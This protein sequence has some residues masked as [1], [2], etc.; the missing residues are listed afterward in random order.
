MSTM[1]PKLDQLFPGRVQSG[2]VLAAFSSMGVGG[3]AEFFLEVRSGRELVDAYRAALEDKLRITV[4]GLGSNMICADAGISGLVIRNASGE[5]EWHEHGCIVDGG[6]E[7][8]ALVEESLRR[9]FVGMENLTSL[10][11]TVGGAIRGGAGA[12]GTEYR[13]RVVWVDALLPTGE[14]VRLNNDECRF[15]YRTSRMKQEGMIVVRA[16]LGFATG[17][18]EAA[19]KRSDEVRVMRREK[20]AAIGEKTAGS[21]FKN[22]FFSELPDQLQSNPAIQALNKGGKIPAWYFIQEVGLT[23]KTIG[24]AQLSPQHANTIVNIGGATASDIVMLT[25]LV[26]QRVRDTFN[27]QLEEEIQYVQ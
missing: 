4:I 27:V 5:I 3:P 10:P 8:N 14:V 11:G 9:G 7:S 6:F 15:G 22:L 1:H 25:S 17:D 12:Y 20:Y 16:E 21:V 2:V 24:G 26:K 18:V 23:G 19:K 13:D